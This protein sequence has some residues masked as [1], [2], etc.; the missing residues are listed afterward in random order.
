MPV[1]SIHPNPQVILRTKTT[2]ITTWPRAAV[3]ATQ[4]CKFSFQMF[5]SNMDWRNTELFNMLATKE[6]ETIVTNDGFGKR[7]PDMN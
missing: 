1:I 6:L 5:V 2:L 7:T 3:P 4:V